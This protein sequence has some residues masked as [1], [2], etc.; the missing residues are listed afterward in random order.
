MIS[1]QAFYTTDRECKVTR[2][3]LSKGDLKYTEIYMF[4][5]FY[6]YIS[7]PFLPVKLNTLREARCEFDV[8][9]VNSYSTKLNFKCRV[10][11]A[12][13]TPTFSFL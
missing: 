11:S 3:Y 5:F 13:L 8:D 4:S 7:V 2:T 9:E 6:I 10:P 1:A 12:T